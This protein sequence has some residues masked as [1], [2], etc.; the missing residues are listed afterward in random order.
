MKILRFLFGKNKY[1]VVRVVSVKVSEFD[2]L[3]IRNRLVLVIVF[4][5]LYDFILILCLV[6]VIWCRVV[7]WC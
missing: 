5:E 4:I 6:R 1:S 2:S 3:I 7:W